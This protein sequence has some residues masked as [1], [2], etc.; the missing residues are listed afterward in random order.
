MNF[1]ALLQS[2]KDIPGTIAR[3]FVGRGQRIES[4]WMESATKLRKHHAHRN[5]RNAMARA[6]RRENRR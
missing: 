4:S 2:L 6:S 1:A 5:V 3:T